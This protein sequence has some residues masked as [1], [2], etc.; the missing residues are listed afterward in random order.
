MMNDWTRLPANY[1][2]VL[3]RAAESLF[4]TFED[5]SA[6]TVV[7]DRDARIVWMNE[8]YAARFG[9]ADPQQAVGLDCEAVIP[10]SLL[11]EVVSS[12]QPILLDIMETGREPLVV[13]RLP[14]K[15]EA[16]E[17]VGAI[18]FALFDQL[19]TLTPIFSRY[20]QLQQQL[21]ATQRSLAQARRAK[22]TF[23][24]FVG[25]SAASLETKR[26]ARRAA[27][28]DSPVLLLGET[29]TGKELLAHAIH[30]ASARA[31][32][33]LVTVN[34]AA[35]PDTLLETEFFGA[36]PG[37]YTGADRKGRVGKFELADRGTLFLDEIG[38]MPL[39]LQGKLL[40]VL[41]DK[42]FEPV[43]SNRIVRADVRIIAAT[44]A[45]LPALVAAGR[46]RADLYYRLNV[47]TIHAPPLR[48]R[49]SD[50]AA[51]VYVTLEELAAQHGRA[52][53]CELT[54]DALRMLCAYPW[55][56]NVR[57]LRN[58]L[59]RALMLSDRAIIDARALAPF[60]GPTRVHADAAPAV[61]PAAVPA[62]GGGAGSRS[63]SGDPHAGQHV[64]YAD[65]LA[66]WERQF[67]TDA[68]AACDGKV[69]EAAA[70]IG[71][72]RATLYKK[73]AALGIGR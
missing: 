67:F 68:L 5:S 13:T 57:E 21:I 44:S 56:G 37:A 48:E 18:G 69:V 53:H 61:P 60:L 29:G 26:Q 39:P 71:I 59:E 4:R 40:R 58:T 31:L 6:G 54:D 50:I 41:Q 65:A 15:N 27:Q 36:A 51:L 33:P 2:D 1:G 34:V 70:R 38:D 10:N 20:A 12:G 17:T 43:G 30:A 25:T 8:R 35:I 47:L 22:Y 55:P 11:R 62:G 9:F 46:F 49:A 42:E 64:S 3:R 73:L 72:G 16:G 45:D 28:V 63:G 52:A 19:K 14:L 23:A 24:S 32:Q 7:V 66:A